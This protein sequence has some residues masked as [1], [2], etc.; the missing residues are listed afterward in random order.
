MELKKLTQ[1]LMYT[2]AVLACLL[3]KASIYANML[4]LLK[5][6]FRFSQRSGKMTDF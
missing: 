2:K 1:I 5:I 6:N 3:S 4:Y